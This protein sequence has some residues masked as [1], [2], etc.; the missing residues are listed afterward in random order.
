VSNFAQTPA[1]YERS[2]WGQKG[3]RGNGEV[4]C[5]TRDATA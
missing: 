3:A 4:S 1:V 5:A 2:F